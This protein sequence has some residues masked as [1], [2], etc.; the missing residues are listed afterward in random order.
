VTD[1]NF[2]LQVI[3]VLQSDFDF[4]NNNAKSL[5]VNDGSE[6]IKQFRL[7]TTETGL[8][9]WQISPETG[10][11]PFISVLPDGSWN[12]VNEIGTELVWYVTLKC[13]IPG[14]NPTVSNIEIEWL[15]EYSY[16]DS[17]G[18]KF[19]SASRVPPAIM[20]GRPTRS[21]ATPSGGE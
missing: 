8:L 10:S 6:P 7:T 17:R 20:A 3:Q 19:V 13:E 11:L 5:P 1:Y 18:E 16:I 9:S 21:G 12:T 4:W 14:V 2:G 15:S